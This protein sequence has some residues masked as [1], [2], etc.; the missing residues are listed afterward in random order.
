MLRAEQVGG[1]MSLFVGVKCFRKVY[2]LI[3]AYILTISYPPLSFSL[4][5][6]FSRYIF[7]LFISVLLFIATCSQSANTT[8][9]ENTA[10][11]FLITTKIDVLQQTKNSCHLL[12]TKL[13]YQLIAVIS[14]CT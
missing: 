5:R 12:S 6:S 9:S 4:A 1:R 7:Y 13:F 3:V 10:F 8:Q 14:C 11:I 2:Y